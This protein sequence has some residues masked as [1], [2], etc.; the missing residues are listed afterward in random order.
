MHP[1]LAEARKA[2]KTRPV[3]QLASMFID[4][5]GN[6][7]AV[8]QIGGDV[9]RLNADVIREVIWEFG[10]EREPYA[11]IVHFE[12]LASAHGVKLR[13]AYDLGKVARE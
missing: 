12:P 1:L 11:A 2:A 6:S 9:R 3:A 10:Y 7:D 5:F 13:D 4:K 8:R